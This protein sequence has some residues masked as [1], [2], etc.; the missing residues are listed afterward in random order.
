MKPQHSTSTHNHRKYKV[1]IV[2]LSVFLLLALAYIVYTVY[3]T[4]KDR[5]PQSTTSGSGSSSVA[6]SNEKQTEAPQTKEVCAT[7]EKLCMKYP[8]NWN[9]EAEDIVLHSTGVQSS[10]S[11]HADKITF[12]HPSGLKLA[13]ASGLTALGGVCTENDNKLS[14]D[15]VRKEATSLKGYRA[16]VPAEYATYVDDSIFAVAMVIPNDD[17]TEFTPD[18]GLSN[19][20]KLINSSQA[21]RC[22]I[23]GVGIVVAKNVNIRSKTSGNSDHGSLFLGTKELSGYTASFQNKSYKTR[24]EAKRA[25]KGDDYKQAFEI[26]RSVYYK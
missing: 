14:V 1:T 12:T 17:E 2:I 18:I 20:S 23:R 22:D 3:T 5:S 13:F 10:E 8:S 24:E 26:A 16:F 21:N 9:V 11:Y 7:N 25:F 19:S 15:I 6:K 4:M